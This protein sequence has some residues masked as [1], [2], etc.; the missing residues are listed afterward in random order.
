MEMSSMGKKKVL[1]ILADNVY[2]TPYLN[3]Y[4]ER[5][6]SKCDFKVMYWDKNDNEIIQSD[7]YIRFYEHNKLIGYIKY[8]KEIINYL[9]NNS[10]DIIIPLHQ[11]IFLLIGNFLLRNY[12]YKYIYDVRDYS[13]EKYY[14]VRKIQNKLVNKSIINIISS[15]GFKE[16]LP[17]AKYFIT[18]NIPNVVNKSIYDYDFYK[19]SPIRISYIGLI[20]FMDQNKKIIDFFKNDMRFEISFIGTNALELEEYCKENKV[21]NVNLVGTFDPKETMR[22]YDETDIIMN[23][24]G[25]HTPLLDYA[26][27]NKFY[28]SILLKKP[29]LVCKDTFMEKVSKEANVGFV[30]ELENNEEKDNLYEYYRNIDIKDFEESCNQYLNKVYSDEKLLDKQFELIL[31]R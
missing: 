25:N 30:M 26:I 12:K 13:Y 17:E 9:K 14:F 23:L 18:H 4:I 19:H 27:S 2:L 29:I 11:I 24:Y 22:F 15:E 21:H 28:Y 6:Q 3:K 10:F 5:I 16:F 8:K 7:K 20:R 1:F 31:N